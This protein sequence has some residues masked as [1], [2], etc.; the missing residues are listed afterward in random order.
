LETV[1]LFADSIQNLPRP[2]YLHCNRG[3]T[4]AYTTLMYM[5]NCTR[6]DP[7]FEPK[8]YSNN[9]YKIV[10]AMG[11]DFTKDHIKKVVAEITGEDFVTD[12]PKPD[13]V[14]SNWRDWWLAHPVAKNWYSAGQITKADIK[15]LEKTGFK[16][17]VNLRFVSILSR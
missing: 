15:V 3:Y 8:I 4:I 9:F 1:Q 6:Y 5:A 7:G 17:I 10:A 14:P 2:I 13:Q 12:P 16:A 11:L